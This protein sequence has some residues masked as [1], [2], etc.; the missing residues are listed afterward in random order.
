MPAS[1]R[2]HTLFTT[3]VQS[4]DWPRL[5]AWLR[6]LS[7]RD[8]R[9]A[10]TALGRLSSQ[11]LSAD[12]L[13]ELFTYL[14]PTNPKAYLVTL[15]KAIVLWQKQGLLSVE[16]PMLIA[17]AQSLGDGDQLID[18]KKFVDYI[19]PLIEDPDVILNYLEAC[20]IHDVTARLRLMFYIDTLPGQYV[21]FQCLRQYE[22][23][24][25]FLKQ[26]I[27]ELRKYASERS[28]NFLAFITAYFDLKDTG[29]VYSLRLLPHELGRV[30]TSYEY[31]HQ[32][33][34]RI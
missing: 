33:M 31:F 1:T 21:L 20:G 17:Y 11:D 25:D 2:L 19:F 22:H 14:V 32:M 4:R 26:Y 34:T 30:E 28:Y 24:T 29:M 16:H 10:C 7:H 8:F 27:Y 9:Q 23:D 5:A 13:L 15:L 3:H 6:G 12:E 18:I